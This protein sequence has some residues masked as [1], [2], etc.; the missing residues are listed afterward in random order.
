VRGH[1]TGRL[2]S[3][4]SDRAR[5]AG[6]VPFWPGRSGPRHGVDPLG[7]AVAAAPWPFAPLGAAEALSRRSPCQSSR[8]STPRC[9]PCFVAVPCRLARMGRLRFVRPTPRHRQHQ[10]VS[11]LFPALSPCLGPT[12]LIHRLATTPSQFPSTS[13]PIAEQPYPACNRVAADAN[14]GVFPPASR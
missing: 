5:A 2:V 8:S 7:L 9:R 13:C 14:F 12:V 4:S 10:Q 3:C 6:R 11:P 1:R